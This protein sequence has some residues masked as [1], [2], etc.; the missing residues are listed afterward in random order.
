M[1]FRTPI[2][3]LLG[4]AVGELATAETAR[5]Y[6]VEISATVQSSPPQIKL[7]W[8]N[9]CPGEALE[10]NVFRK[11]EADASW[12]P[13]VTLCG[14]ATMYVDNSVRVGKAYEY[15]VIRA[16]PHFRAYGYVY[17]GIEVPPA[18]HRGTLL[19]VV[20]ATV[21]ADLAG[22]LNQLQEDLTGDG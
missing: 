16:T 10:Y 22:E 20:D 15:Q 5:D 12:G 14:N 4:V 19:L 3:L 21:A 8:D 18:E 7:D 2:F 6:A 1:V 13:G 11:A 17:T 9:R